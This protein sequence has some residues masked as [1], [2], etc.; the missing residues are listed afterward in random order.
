[1]LRTVAII[2]GIF[3]LIAGVLGF[4]PAYAPDGNLFCCF[5]I[6][7]AHNIVHIA[8]G[9]IALWAGFSSH[10]ASKIF[11]RVFGVLYFFVALLGIYYGDQPILGVI[12]NNMA[13]VGLHLV[14][15]VIALYLGFRTEKT[16]KA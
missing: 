8:T 14:I 11:F 3:F 13:D 4:M 9:I 1:M 7:P 2:F 5:R 16:Q 15:A 10:G 12:A 6:N